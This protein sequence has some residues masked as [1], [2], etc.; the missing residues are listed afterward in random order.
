MSPRPLPAEMGRDTDRPQL[1]GLRPSSLNASG[2]IV[3][4]R[5]STCR[6]AVHESAIHSRSTRSVRQLNHLVRAEER[7][8]RRAESSALPVLRLVT[9]LTLADHSKVRPKPLA[10][11]GTLSE[12][13]G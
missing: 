13:R 10:P 3:D 2:L 8:Y 5:S 11:V 7:G 1:A 6:C 12:Q 9:N 4:G